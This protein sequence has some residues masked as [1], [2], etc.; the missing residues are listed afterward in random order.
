MVGSDVINSLSDN[1]VQA[2]VC[3]ALY[4]NTRNLCFQHYPW[5]FS[6]KQIDLGGAVSA[7]PLFD[8]KYA[9]QIPVDALRIITM[10]NAE[11]Y[12][13]FEDKLL[14]NKQITRIVYQALIAENKMPSYFVR[15]LELRMAELLSM[16]LQEDAQ[17]M[18]MF[19]DAA[20]KEMR[21]AR[22]L[23]AQ[24]QTP[25]KIPERNYTFINVRG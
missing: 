14:S 7:S 9:F 19:A 22:N 18:R 15:L 23:D 10:E 12:A 24:Q 6:L 1:S 8:W 13:I 11:D 20:D 16:S 17:K 4:A 5:R 25:A 3:S 2:K 21:R